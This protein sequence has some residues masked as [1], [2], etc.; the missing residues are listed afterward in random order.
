[1]QQ[2][3]TKQK[4]NSIQCVFVVA[5]VRSNDAIFL[6]R[7]LVYCV[8]YSAKLELRT[9]FAWLFVIVVN[10]SLV[11]ACHLLANLDNYLHSFKIIAAW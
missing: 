9:T 8:E 3:R 4:L 1:M 6:T 2:R 11:H 7:L 10:R 5:A